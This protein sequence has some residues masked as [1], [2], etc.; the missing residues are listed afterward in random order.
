MSTL[1]PFTS[2]DT[3]FQKV[4]GVLNKI[5][6]TVKPQTNENKSATTMKAQKNVSNFHRLI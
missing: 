2:Y 1:I 3:I 6:E 4:N 5:E